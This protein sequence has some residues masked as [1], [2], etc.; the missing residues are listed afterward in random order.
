LKDC[1]YRGTVL[2]N[3]NELRP[4]I[5]KRII[6]A[7]IAYYALLPLLKS[8]SVPRAQK[9]KIYKTLIRPVVTYRAEAW[10]LNKDIA[11]GLAV[12]EQKILRRI[13]GAIKVNENWRQ[14]HNK[15][16][17]QVFGDLDILSFVRISRLKWIG[18]VNKM[19]NKRTVSQV[20]NNNPQ[21]SRPRG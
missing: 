10:T 13:F 14:R 21:G 3:K 7:N 16:L 19:E 15:E 1:T 11:K 2:T 6:N 20:F 12:F 18:Q 4:E 17:K 9:V 8:Q 5:E